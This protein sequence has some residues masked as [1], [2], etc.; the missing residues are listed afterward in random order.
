MPANAADIT[1]AD[2][3]TKEV[4]TIGPNATLAEAADIFA[5]HGYHALPVVDADANLVGMLTDEDLVATEARVHVPT[6]INLGA[7]GEFPW[8]GT[9]HRLEEEL[10]AISAAT[11]VDLM[12][13]DFAQLAPSDNVEV[14]ATKMR[15]HDVS[16][17]PVV[18][19]DEL[20]GIVARADLIRHLADTT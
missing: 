11:V 14:I 13:T 17:L 18:D 19:G 15:D 1:A 5:D 6:M 10:R 2:V 7:F 9:M 8:P 4:I 20:V 12:E 3:M 16:H